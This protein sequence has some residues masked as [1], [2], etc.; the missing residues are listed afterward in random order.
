MAFTNANQRPTQLPPDCH[1]YPAQR[2]GGP[3][4][5]PSCRLPAPA[6]TTD[7][8]IAALAMSSPTPRPLRDPMPVTPAAVR[9]ARLR[10]GGGDKPPPSAPPSN[11]RRPLP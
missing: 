3:A 4:A 8:A 6:R 11:G 9:P 5:S 10:L 2:L 7:H 1:T